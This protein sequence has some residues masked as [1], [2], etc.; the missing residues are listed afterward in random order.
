MTGLKIG[1]TD[2]ADV[3]I[4]TTQVEAV[5]AGTNEVWTN[6]IQTPFVWNQTDLSQFDSSGT[7][8]PPERTLDVRSSWSAQSIYTANANYGSDQRM[9][10][11]AAIEVTPGQDYRITVAFGIS[12]A[13]RF[14]GVYVGVYPQSEGLADWG[15]DNGFRTPSDPTAVML[16]GYRTAL[17]ATG[18][19][20]T[21]TIDFNSPTEA[22]LYLYYCMRHKL[23]TSGNST[24]HVLRVDAI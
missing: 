1:T 16:A 20:T 12:S 5:Y 22:N 11:C 23:L 3:K 17:P 10:V 24:C 21:Y 13:T 6:V 15:V 14:N 4:G 8:A 7:N 2:I 18:S 9:G 19:P